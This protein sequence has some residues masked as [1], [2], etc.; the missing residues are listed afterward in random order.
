M[1]NLLTI[2]K[3]VSYVL[4]LSTNDNLI[5]NESDSDESK[6]FKILELHET[7]RISDFPDQLKFIFDKYHDNVIR[8]GVL[9]SYVDNKKK[10]Y[11]SL[12]CSIMFS[13]DQELFKLSKKSL[14]T[15]F[16]S[17][18][19]KILYDFDKENLYEKFDYQKFGLNKE[20]LVNDILVFKD[21]IPLILFLSDYFSLNIYIIDCSVEK[22]Y[23]SYS[24]DNLNRYK[25]SVVL[26]HYDDM[27]EPL[28]FNK[29]GVW[30]YTNPILNS[31][32]RNS[33][34]LLQRITLNM[35]GKPTMDVY[36]G[37]ENL[38]KYLPKKDNLLFKV[39]DNLYDFSDDEI[40]EGTDI[41]ENGFDEIT[42]NGSYNSD[43]ENEFTDNNISD[44]EKSITFV[45][46]KDH[47]T[48]KSSLLEI[49]EYAKKH[50]VSI[51]KKGASGKNILKTKK[52]LLNDID[53]KYN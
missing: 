8:Y 5:K 1:S 44:D 46:K 21:G 14:I 28:F 17:L 49:Q 43:S 42:D 19:E 32:V 29:S 20:E 4:K 10:I 3:V 45:S 2:D 53:K 24:E 47:P 33:E 31:L 25:N 15:Y 13:L 35:I 40:E 50:D 34:Q 30:K 48:L 18:K 9:D 16:M 38:D 11:V 52:D 7:D 6:E 12:I 22:V 37:D 23:V 39:N 36:V 51:Y 41:K 26:I 27:Y